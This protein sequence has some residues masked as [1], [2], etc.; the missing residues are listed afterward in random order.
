[1]KIIWSPLSLQRIQE[2]SDYIAS[3]SITAANNWIDS[4]FDKVE[5]LK[6][7]PDIGRV[8]PELEKTDIRELLH[9]NY[10]IIY[11]HTSRQIAILTIRHFKQI[12]PINEIMP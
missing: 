4:I 5:L 11:V 9:G 2:I 12:L 3:D 1:M 6:S 7:N 10:R 8:V